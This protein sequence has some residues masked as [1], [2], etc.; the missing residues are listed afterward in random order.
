MRLNFCFP[1]LQVIGLGLLLGLA[2]GQDAA[3]TVAKAPEKTANYD[4]QVRQNH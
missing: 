3:A 1:E 4:K 2:R